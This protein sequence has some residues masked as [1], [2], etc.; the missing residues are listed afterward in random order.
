METNS[1]NR[2]VHGMM[3]EE[4]LDACDENIVVHDV[5][6]NPGKNLSY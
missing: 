2:V 1:L 4:I 5:S 3:A 6:I